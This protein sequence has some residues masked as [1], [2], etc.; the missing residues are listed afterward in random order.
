MATVKDKVVLITGAS[1]GI[2]L[3]AAKIFAREGAKVMLSARRENELARACEEMRK[4]GADVAYQVTDVSRE[5]EVS[6]LIENTIKAFGRID[7]LVNN[8]GY[9]HFFTLE[10]TTS[11]QL[12]KLMEVNLYGSFYPSRLV[13][14]MMRKQGYGHIIMVSSVAGKRVFRGVGGAYNVSK[15]AMQGL[16]EAFRMEL[17]DSPI[18]VTSI[19]PVTTT[20]EFFDL[21]EKQTG[22]KASLHGPQQTAEQVAEVIV[23]VVKRPRAEVIMIGALRLLFALQALAPGLA[24]RLVARFMK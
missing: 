14:P 15:F 4:N 11:E 17:I 9:G 16:A 22:K 20:T 12:H 10:N 24:D 6:Q 19:C 18:H 8:A 5:A 13:V 3:A 23:G 7:V 1:S 21:S 2:G